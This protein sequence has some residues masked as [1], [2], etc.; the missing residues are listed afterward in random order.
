MP[1]EETRVSSW[2]ETMR[3]GIPAFDEERIR[4]LR[5]VELLDVDPEHGI[6]GEFFLDRLEI[7]RVVLDKLY[8][9][10]E[11]LM[12]ELKLPAGLREKHRADHDRVMGMFVEVY[13]DSMHRVDRRAFEVYETLRR[14]I[15]QHIWSFG[16]RLKPYVPPTT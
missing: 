10:E 11:T 5:I 16:M 1:D 14:N 15:V 12:D 7:L 3:I 2:Q 13:E 9:Y 6:R 8:H 4:M